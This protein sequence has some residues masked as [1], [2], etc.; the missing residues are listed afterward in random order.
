LGGILKQ[1]GEINGVIHTSGVLRDSAIATKDIQ[2]IEEVFAAKALPAWEIYKFFSSPNRKTD[3][4]ALFSSV[5]V[6]LAALGQSDYAAASACLDGIAELAWSRGLPFVSVAWPAWREVGMAARTLS[7]QNE[8]YRNSVSRVQGAQAFYDIV[9]RLDTPRSVVSVLPFD[10]LYQAALKERQPTSHRNPET[11]KSF[12]AP[13]EQMASI[14]RRELKNNNIAA[15]DDYFAVGGDSLFAVQL[16][17]RIKETFDQAIPMSLFIKA[18][19]PRQLV[20]AMGLEASLTGGENSNE[21]ATKLPGH[22]IPLRMEA[23]ESETPI[24]CI[25]AADGSVM[26]YQAFATRV[27]SGHSIYGVESKMLYDENYQ[28]TD[29]ETMAEE[30]LAAIKKVKPSGPY[31]FAGYSFGALVALRMAQLAEAA[32]DRVDGVILFDMYNPREL[33]AYSIF[34]RLRVIWGQR[35][36]LE[37][38]PRVV[39]S[40]KRC[41]ELVKLAFIHFREWYQYKTGRITGEYRL[42]VKARYLNELLIP[43]FR[44]ATYEGRALIILTEDPGDKYDFGALHGWKNVLT[45]RLIHRFVTGNHLEIFR[46]PHLEGLVKYTNSFLEGLQHPT[47][48]G[49]QDKSSKRRLVENLVGE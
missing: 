36:E 8:L 24:F 46:H 49:R 39:S 1:H 13:V 5:S 11:L 9:T 14:W 17:S 26:F 37:F 33:R 45:G 34:E 16:L 22:I 23:N 43:N 3:F 42:H 7:V 47:H 15:D 25:H 21:P 30:Y 38:N 4:V 28:V 44:P 6:D 40:L 32:G 27:R 35:S 29:I 18:P 20:R 41:A 19:T 12:E 2:P 10:Q 31:L 48:Q